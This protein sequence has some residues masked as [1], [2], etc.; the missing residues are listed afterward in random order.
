MFQ[1]KNYN[2]VPGMIMP[3]QCEDIIK[4]AKKLPPK[5]TVVEIGC[6]WGKS[7]WCWLEGFPEESRL[8]TI[9]VF[10][11]DNKKGKHKKRQQT[12]GN[13]IIDEI[14]NYWL[15]HTGLETL[16]KVLEEHPRKNVIDHFIYNGTSDSFDLSSIKK[17]DC[18]YIDGNHSYN[19]VKADLEKF[20]D[21]SEI[22]CGDDYKP[23]GRSGPYKP[24]MGVV[25]AV[26]EYCEKNNRQFWTDPESFFW[27]ALKK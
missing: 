23:E 4:I 25:E 9:D 20:G 14:M 10:M 26:D 19:Y 3:S 1:I 11:L 6:A 17:I 18:V 21:I 24:Q 5:S 16:K 7:T 15:T 2:D 27:T 8:I 13:P 22:I 12:L